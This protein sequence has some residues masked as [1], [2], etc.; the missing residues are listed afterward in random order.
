MKKTNAILLIAIPLVFILLFFMLF[1]LLRGFKEKPLFDGEEYGSVLK[2][3]TD[4]MDNEGFCQGLTADSFK[5]IVSQY[6]YEEKPLSEIAEWESKETESGN[7]WSLRDG[8][9]NFS[10]GNYD[11]EQTASVRTAVNLT[12]LD[13]PC[14]ITFGDSVSAVLEKLGIPFDYKQYCT[15]NTRIVPLIKNGDSS[16]T[17]CYFNDA[18]IDYDCTVALDFV[19]TTTVKKDKNIK[20]SRYVLLKFDGVRLFEIYV[21]VTEQE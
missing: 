13:I 3:F 10:I 11:K 16:L 21:H 8:C 14:N 6:E 17:F 1:S 19:E 2:T 20:V 4:F 9:F 12:G 18:A 5:K 15:E 7:R